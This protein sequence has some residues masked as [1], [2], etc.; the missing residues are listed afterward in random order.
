MSDVATA[1]DQAIACHRA[2]RMLDAEQLYRQILAVDAANP[3][4]LYL[5]N[6][7][8]AWRRLMF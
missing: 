7:W 2:G 3:E 4:V 5:L 1:L 6:I 8:L